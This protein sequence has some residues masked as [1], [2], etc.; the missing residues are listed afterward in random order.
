MK[1]KIEKLRIVAFVLVTFFNL[2]VNAQTKMNPLENQNP[3]FPKGEKTSADYF[4]GTAWLNVLV[5]KDETGKYTIGNVEFEPGCRN[6]WHTHPAGQILLV[7]EGKGLYQERGKPAR[8]L[9]KGDVVVIPSNT[10]HWHGAT[11][12]SHFTHIA[13][14]NMTEKGAVNWLKPVTEEEYNNCQTTK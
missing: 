7:I 9:N 3:I 10:E 11:K 12:D 5:P 4:T 8:L 2:H 1:N 13:I 6:N 14:T